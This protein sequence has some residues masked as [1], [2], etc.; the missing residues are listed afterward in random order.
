LHVIANPLA[1]ITGTAFVHVFA[2]CSKQNVH[3]RS[4]A[5]IIEMHTTNKY[6]RDFP[7]SGGLPVGGKLAAPI[8][9]SIGTIP[10]P[11]PLLD[12]AGLDRI[13]RGSSC[14]HAVWQDLPKKQA[15]DRQPQVKPPA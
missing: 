4:R 2:V 15:N 13:S 5:Q 10:S 14:L 9:R 6:L 8:S 12:A 11:R 7:A 1:Q 3:T